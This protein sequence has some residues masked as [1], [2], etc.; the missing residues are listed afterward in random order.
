MEDN[1][2]NVVVAPYDCVVPTCESLVLSN[3]LSDELHS[4]TP[5]TPEGE[6]ENVTVTLERVAPDPFGANKNLP[7]GLLVLLGFA[8][9]G[10]NEEPSVNASPFDVANV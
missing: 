3:V 4:F 9:G 1:P 5:E 2:L 8:N 7:T 10:V 6:P